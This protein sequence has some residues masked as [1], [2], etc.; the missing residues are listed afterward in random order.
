MQKQWYT[1]ENPQEEVKR[2]ARYILYNDDVQVAVFSV[3]SSVI[4]EFIPQKPELLPRQIC[5]A[6][7][8]GF[9]SW[10]R[11]RAVDLN[12]V[13][14]RNLMN[15][16]VGS[17]DRTTIALRTH[18]F[19]ISDTF[20]CFE[21]GEFTPRLQLCQPEDQDAVSDFILVSSDT[22]LR[23]LRISTPNAS[24]DGSFTKTW[25]Y[26][27]GEW[28]LYKL[29][30]SAATRIEVGISRVLHNIG[31]DAAEYRF[32][33]KYLKRVKT[34]NFLQPQE[35]FEPYDSF[36]F[37]FDDP[38]DDEEVIYQNIAS[39]G[40]EFEKAWKRILLADA[41][42]VNT[43]RHMRNFG[44][45]RSSRTGEVLRLAPNFDNNQA[46]L[47][48]PG[49][50]YSDGMLKLYMKQADSLDY[51]NLKTLAN[52]LKAHP[53]LKHACDACLAYLKQG[54][55]TSLSTDGDI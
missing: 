12:S 38:S 27:E 8:D 44:V 48:N 51:Q 34:R 26:E 20:T 2:V 24:T 11:E 14:H 41:V 4:T 28:W 7:A 3:H 36:R 43:D 45:I 31:W 33:G 21:E 50:I 25:K 15:E 5:H 54:K 55:R 53:Y 46:Y 16:L 6:T 13:K 39:L 22:S 18:M 30:P 32:V 49:G 17:R 35:F 37:S 42:F 52:E 10:L 47:A 29:Q 19:S 1:D 23:K 40:P 9:T